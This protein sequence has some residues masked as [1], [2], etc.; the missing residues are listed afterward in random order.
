MSKVADPLGPWLWGRDLRYAALAVICLTHGPVSIAELAAR[1]S[2]LGFDPVDHKVLADALGHEVRRGRLVR[3]ARGVYREGQIASRT[4]ER[5]LSRWRRSLPLPARPGP[6]LV[7]VD[8]EERRTDD[9]ITI[10]TVYTADD[11]A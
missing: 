7:R 5:I 2:D 9:G 6:N 3:V 1:L 11:L 4:R 10:R 8:A